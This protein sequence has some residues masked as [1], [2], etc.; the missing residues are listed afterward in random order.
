[1][2][3]QTSSKHQIRNGS[4]SDRHIEN[5]LTERVLSIDWSNM[6]HAKEIL[7]NKAVI[8]Y[9]ALAEG[10]VM[11]EGESRCVFTTP[12]TNDINIVPHVTMDH[13]IKVRYDDGRVV[14]NQKGEKIHTNI[15]Y[16]TH[17]NGEED[18]LY[19]YYLS[20]FNPDKTPYLF[21]RTCVLKLAY[22]IKTTIWVT[23][24]LQQI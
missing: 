19:V 22:P 24:L 10:L 9:I 5:G 12:I 21:E 18:E 1:M 23:K 7:K 13:E 15:T 14:I 17:E 11:N 2:P 3:L 6:S 16:V 20:F 8:D 4:I